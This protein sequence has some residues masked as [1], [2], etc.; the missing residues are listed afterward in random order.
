[1]G[2]PQ[3]LK[4]FNTTFQVSTR[5][6]FIWGTFI[7]VIQWE[8]SSHR[9][10]DFQTFGQIVKHFLTEPW[11][12]G[13]NEEKSIDIHDVSLTFE[14]IHSVDFSVSRK[15]GSTLQT[16]SERTRRPTPANHCVCEGASV[17]LSFLLADTRRQKCFW[18]AYLMLRVNPSNIND[19]ESAAKA[20]QERPVFVKKEN[21]TVWRAYSHFKMQL[22][23]S[24]TDYKHRSPCYIKYNFYCIDTT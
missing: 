18:N 10:A 22:C 19:T 9:V 13:K 5:L 16:L 3:M 24:P 12:E 14:M 6:P 20:T 1:M 8:S 15:I 21:D 11:S 2:K 23:T 7:T 4:L 17:S